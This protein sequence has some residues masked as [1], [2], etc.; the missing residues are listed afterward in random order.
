MFSL[1][2]NR[3]NLQTIVLGLDWFFLN[4]PVW[5]QRSNSI[6]A[7]IPNSSFVILWT[8]SSQT[9]HVSFGVSST[10]LI[11]RLFRR[12]QSS[13]SISFSVTKSRSRR[14]SSN[15]FIPAWSFPISFFILVSS[16]PSW[17]CVNSRLILFQILP[18]IFCQVGCSC[19]LNVF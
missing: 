17:P 13:N 1:F 9:S 11:L 18:W 15:S 6:S 19:F 14:S 7:V 10:P 3:R 12:D 8:F 16:L 5:W 2:L 4:L